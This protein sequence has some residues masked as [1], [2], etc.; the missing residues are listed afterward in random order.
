MIILKT[1]YFME[2]I[3]LL[4]LLRILALSISL[5]FISNV[6]SIPRFVVDVVVQLSYVIKI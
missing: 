6:T 1:R 3:I 5:Y 2:K 4:G